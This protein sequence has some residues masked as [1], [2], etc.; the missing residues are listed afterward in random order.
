MKQNS[1]VKASG[2]CKFDKAIHLITTGFSR[3]FSYKSHLVAETPNFLFPQKYELHRHNETFY[4]E[5]HLCYVKPPLKVMVYSSLISYTL[6]RLRKSSIAFEGRPVVKTIVPCSWA[7]LSA[8]K[9]Q[10]EIFLKKLVKSHL[11]LRQSIYICI[12]ILHISHLDTLPR[13]LQWPLW[14]KSLDTGDMRITLLLA[15]CVGSFNV[16]KCHDLIHL[17]DLISRQFDLLVHIV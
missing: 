16:P 6:V 12:I 5:F 1:N 8:T 4:Q 11:N 3:Q 10:A 9:F 7:A 2:D 14:H 15:S 17:K 13:W